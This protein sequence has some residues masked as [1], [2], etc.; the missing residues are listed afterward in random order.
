[1]SSPN[2]LRSTL[3]QLPAIDT[4][5]RLSL[6]TGCAKKFQYQYV[7]GM[8]GKD[9]GAFILGNTVHNGLQNWFESSEQ[10][11]EKAGLLWTKMAEAWDAE[12]PSGLKSKVK[13]EIKWFQETEKVASAIKLTRP[14][15][16]NVTATKEYKESPEVQKLAHA[17]EK[18]AKWL[19][20]NEA[21]IRWSKAEPPLKS[22]QVARRIAGEL[23]PE[24][25]GRPRPVLIESSFH[26]EYSGFVWRGR[27]DVY[28]PV[29]AD[30][31]VEPLLIDWKTSQ[32]PPTAMEVFYQATIY[33]LAINEGFGMNLDEVHFR[34]LR[35]G[36]TVKIKVD[37]DKHYPMLVER[38][39]QL[40]SIINDQ[41]IYAPNY[42]Y[43]CKH[44]DFAP[45]CESELG[46]IVS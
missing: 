36:E 13:E 37:P 10:E 21:S 16:A 25:I 22:W 27:I 1:M 28:G 2:S 45:N 19:E 11:R 15:V 29:N 26:F 20:A 9:A 39:S 14:S 46:L 42:S 38:R 41:G 43:T 31:E 3:S 40:E 5:S 33:H 18:T 12:L 30:G 6:A 23:E 24:W 8:R 17:S 35:R 44:C 34:I 32:N 7:H 4:A